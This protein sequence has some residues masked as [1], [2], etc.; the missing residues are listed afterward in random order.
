M[1]RYE[2]I[3]T[4][5]E[6]ELSSTTRFIQILSN[7]YSIS[8]HNVTSKNTP[9]TSGK[10]FIDKLILRSVN[11]IQKEYTISKCKELGFEISYKYLS[12][13]YYL[14][15]NT[16]TLIIQCCLF[17]E[18]HTDFNRI[19]LNPSKASHYFKVESILLQ[20]FGPSILNS[21]IYRIDLSVDIYKPYEEVIQGLD[22]QNKS[23]KSEYLDKTARTGIMVGTDN[24]K[25]IVYDKSKE[26][27][28]DEHWTRIERQ[29]TA[30]KVPVKT[31]MQLRDALPEI[32]ELNLLGI[33]T[34]NDIKLI[35]P[36]IPDEKY[37]ELKAL[38]KHQGL[39]LARKKLNKNNNFKRDYGKFFSLTP[40]QYQPSDYLESGL[41]TFFKV[42]GTNEVIH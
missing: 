20:L 8:S 25:I 36:T 40:Y 14:I 17:R 6:D 21:Q 34:L 38:I 22:I 27:K 37:Y 10:G 28:T 33:V 39:F 15:I 5:T 16:G 26:Q 31:L 18:D 23:A 11:Y 7:D 9:V 1:N 4:L 3:A 19:I 42:G 2:G 13:K 30:S 29:L 41:T 12:K 24:D 32:L 35:E